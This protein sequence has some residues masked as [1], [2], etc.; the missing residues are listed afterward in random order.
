MKKLAVDMSSFLWRALTA[1]TDHENGKVVFFN[2]KEVTVNSAIYGYEIVMTMLVNLL[3]ETGHQPVDTLLVF[4]GKSSKSKRM[5]LDSTY[6]GG[7]GVASHPTESYIEFQTLSDRLRAVWKEVGATC[8][9][10]DFAEGDDTLA[11]LAREWP[12]PLTIATYDNDISA[13]NTEPGETNAY[14]G[15]CVVWVGG[16][17]GLNK[18]G[19]FDFRRIRVY[20]ALVGDSSDKIKGVSGFGPGAFDKLVMA[21]GWDGMD[22][23]EAMLDAGDLGPLEG[24]AEETEGKGKPTVLA[25]LA[26]LMLASSDSFIKAWR[27]VKLYPEWV[28]TLRNPLAIVA[29]K[30]SSEPVSRDERLNEWYGQNFLVTAAEYQ[31]AME[32]LAAEGPN[33]PFIAF[34]IET[35]TP[36]ESDDWLAAQG[37]PDGVDAIG[38]VLTGFSLTFGK[39]LQYTVYVSVDHAST[40]NVTMVQAREMLE[41]VWSFGKSAV[42][43]NNFFELPV[44]YQAQ[45]EDGTLWRDHWKG[46]GY[47]GFCPNV[48][49]TKLEG[50][51]VNENIKLGLKARSLLHLGYAQT[52]YDDTTKLSGAVGSLPKGGRLVAESEVEG[53]AVQTRRYK[54]REL[55]AEAVF[56][57]G[58]DDTVCTAALH[59]YY[60]L[61]MHLE[62]TYQVYLDVEI[63][64]SYLHA[65]SFVDGMT[66]SIAKSKELEKID[67]V[68]QAQAWA[69]VRACLMQNGWDG[70]VPPVFTPDLK[71][72]EMKHAY[73]IVT[74]QVVG[75]LIDVVENEDE[76][77]PEAAEVEEVTADPFLKTKV[78]T[79]SK[80]LALLRSEG[81]EVFAGKLEAC[82]AGEA[83]A[84]TTYVNSYFKGEPIFKS[85][86]HQVGHLMY[87]VLGLPVQVRGK[88]TAKM[89]LRGILQGNRKADSLAI[90]Y[91]L[92]DAADRPDVV[93]VLNSLRLMQMV[94]TRR[95]LFYSKYPNFVHW[96]TGKVHS[97]HNQC[98]TNTRRASESKPNKQQLPKHAKI[99]GQA[100][101]FRE[102]IVPHAP[103]AVIVSMDFSAQELRV[104]ADYSKDPN[105]VACY[106]GENKKD[107]HSFIGVG[108][109]K[110]R[111]KE[112]KDWTYETFMF[113]LKDVKS[114]EFKF[115]KEMRALGKK[116]GFT[117]EYGAMAPKLAATLL[118][119]ETEAQSY[120]DAK[121]DAF[122]VAKAWKEG[123]T[124]EAR[125]YGF[126][127]TKL[128]AVRHLREALVNGDRWEQSKA[129]R[130]SV[131]FKIQSSSSEMT[132]Q[133]EGR[134]WTT[135]LF[136]NFD[137]VCYGPVHDEVVASCV[138]E[139]LPEFLEAMHACMVAPYADMTIPILSE[140]S[141]GSSFGHQ[142][143]VGAVPDRKA[144]AQALLE[145]G[146]VG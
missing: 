38:S 54:M 49:D 58:A 129:D 65:K 46:N 6:K 23:L 39:N 5:L 66:V 144:I 69:T 91:A 114:P 110:A 121:E 141:F 112:R 128:G 89:K 8:L 68:T 20:K 78:R 47:H 48:L 64:A 10:Q 123:V 73:R 81:H 119:T 103:N 53:V 113:N 108:I 36:D 138:V 18:Y 31:D 28:S 50:S 67:D 25:K 94:K 21:A 19:A 86:T 33:S 80:L 29:G 17:I 92:R 57:Y 77:A 101:R 24:L 13:L 72:A 140:I 105:M 37:D 117:T 120:I 74:D 43:Q 85:G 14:G 115:C 30:V 124:Q 55:T 83:E 107:M 111:H 4:E 63:A 127:A 122:P 135:G 99:E 26:K 15:T 27:V 102:V 35:S 61:V 2:D 106:V 51:Y 45:D 11:Y 42:I 134:M 56:G 116:V 84:F 32:T 104:I 98:G 145:L 62:H 44:L 136:F 16:K 146:M 137:A 96:K 109:V 87:D 9:T 76:D 12:G 60:S 70:T 142:I 130:Q 41:L 34:D 52:S 82:F 79:N 93:A 71:V 100:A 143:E 59:V 132:K 133:A 7:S 131:N 88:P 90:E 75:G 125:K 126:V 3:K 97:S 139:D 95:G 118:C 22:E 1:G 40:S